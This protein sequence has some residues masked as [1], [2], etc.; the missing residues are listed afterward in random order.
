MDFSFLNNFFDHIYVITLSRATNRQEK[1]V[2]L[3]DGLNFTFFYGADK[4]NF[5][6]EELITKNIYD[7]N[8]ASLLHRYNKSMNTGQIGCSWSHKLVYEDVI[9]NN[10]NR[11]LI[12]EDDV[13]PISSGLEFLPEMVKQL[14][15]DWELW[16]MDY[17]KN[18]KSNLGTATKQMVYHL[19]RFAGKLNYTS[20]TIS[21]LY[22]KKYTPNL[23]KAGYHDF[24]SAYAITQS[25]AKKLIQ[26]QSPI[27]FIADNLLAYSSS[28]KLVK[29]FISIPKV[30]EQESQL[31][32][33]STR[34]SFVEE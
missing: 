20:S 1:I 33:P 18:T 16:Y 27:A 29:A 21:H 28:N 24:T 13:F 25:A 2:Q 8:K 30:F 23:L 3:L 7:D 32:D 10:F 12:L 19:Q 11:V 5:T 9:K 34:E 6:K 17:Q 31:T 26:L 4:L 22:A 15:P 14:P